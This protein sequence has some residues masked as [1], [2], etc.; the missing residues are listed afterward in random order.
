MRQMR[1]QLGM[2]CIRILCGGRAVAGPIP[3]RRSALGSKRSCTGRP[4]L[5][6]VEPSV[7]VYEACGFWF[8]FAAQLSALGMFA[9]GLPAELDERNKR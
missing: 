2:M 9:T 4:N 5:S 6:K 3:S 1:D 8:F 7:R